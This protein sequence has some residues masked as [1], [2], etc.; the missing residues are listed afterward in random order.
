MNGARRTIELEA[1]IA[2]GVEIIEKERRIIFDSFKERDGV[3]R[4]ASQR[5][6]IAKYDKWLRR[7]RKALK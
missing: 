2:S 4:E 3:V 6:E 1:L 7:A 5:R